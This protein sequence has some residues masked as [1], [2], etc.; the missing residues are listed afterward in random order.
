MTKKVIDHLAKNY[1]KIREEVSE[2]MGGK[3]LDHEAKDILRRGYDRGYGNGYGNG[4]DEGIKVTIAQ[5]V[6]DG[7]I[8]IADGAKRLGLKE[9]ELAKYM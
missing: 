1:K 5:F 6:K 8:G 9:E 4:Y 7:I 2:S 3:I